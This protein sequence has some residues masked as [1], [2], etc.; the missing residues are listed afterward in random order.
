MAFAVRIGFRCFVF[1]SC[2]FVKVNVRLSHGNRL[3]W[4]FFFRL[5]RSEETGFF[6]SVNRSGQKGHGCFL[7]KTSVDPDGL[8]RDP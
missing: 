2:I 5:F 7:D 4:L 6:M 3:G 8:T 1:D